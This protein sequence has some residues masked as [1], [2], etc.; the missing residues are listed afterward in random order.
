MSA[1]EQLNYWDGPD[2]WDAAEADGPGAY[3]GPA[4]ERI[5]NDAERAELNTAGW[6]E[7]GIKTLWCHADAP[8]LYSTDE[9]LA[10][11]RFNAAATEAELR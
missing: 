10:F 2:A 6:S 3:G 8:H 7:T 9:A 11:V 5:A 1:T 4:D